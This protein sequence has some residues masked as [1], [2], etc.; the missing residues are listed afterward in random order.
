[1]LETGSRFADMTGSAKC[2]RSYGFTHGCGAAQPVSAARSS[3]AAAHR[4]TMA[5]T[6]RPDPR[7]DS[8]IALLPDQCADAIQIL[9]LV[10]RLVTAVQD[11]HLAG[12]VDDNR[13]RHARHVVELTHLAVLVEQDREAHRGFLQPVD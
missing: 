1:M 9:V 6:L 2:S 8:R 10:A 7:G 4:A 11:A 12:A 5:A 13:T 3:V